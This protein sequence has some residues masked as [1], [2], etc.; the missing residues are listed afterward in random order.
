MANPADEGKREIWRRRLERHRESGATVARFC[1]DE[2]VSVNTFYYWSKRVAPRGAASVARA[3]A[4]VRRADP[5]P[6]AA[7]TDLGRFRLGPTVEVTVPA[8]RLDAIRCLAE[9]LAAPSAERSAAF[10]EIVV[11]ARR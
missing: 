6:A 2:G 5:Q 9:C 8:E 11:A 10:Q 7:G 3:A 4:D 1:Q